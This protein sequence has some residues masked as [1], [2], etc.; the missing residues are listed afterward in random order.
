M[1]AI[2]CLKKG[3]KVTI[4]EMEDVLPHTL[5]CLEMNNVTATSAIAC[6]W[7]QECIQMARALTRPA[8]SV[9]D[10]DIGSGNLIVSRS[11]DSAEKMS[12]SFPDEV[13]VLGVEVKVGKRKRKKAFCDL[14]QVKEKYTSSGLSS[15]KSC[16]MSDGEGLYDR[17][18]MADVLYHLEDFGPLVSTVMGCIA[19]KGV[20]VICYE[21]RRK[22]LDPF[23]NTLRSCFHSHEEHE[24][25]IE[26]ENDSSSDVVGTIGLTTIFGLHIFRSRILKP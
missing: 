18:I 26:R 23:F 24:I 21:Q 5:K 8:V 13:P 15:D 25:K 7:G 11:N 17:I 6:L 20:L 9:T 4:Q 1:A 19:P 22:N 2:I 10:T 16:A 14:N 12:E 3:A